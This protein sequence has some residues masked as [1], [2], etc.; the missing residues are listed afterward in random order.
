MSCDISIVGSGLDGIVTGAVIAKYNPNCNIHI[1]D[2]DTI[3]I[4]DL[5]LKYTLFTIS[6]WAH[7]INIKHYNTIGSLEYLNQT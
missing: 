6:Q 7:F 5:K 1:L 3:L 4:N 2:K